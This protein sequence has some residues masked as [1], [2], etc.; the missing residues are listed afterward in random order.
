VIN[1]FDEI[2]EIDG[3]SL[4]DVIYSDMFMCRF[5][6]DACFDPN[7]RRQPY[8]NRD[9]FLYSIVMHLLFL[10]K[11]VEAE[12]HIKSIH[13]GYVRKDL[14]NLLNQSNPKEVIV[15]LALEVLAVR[16]RAHSLSRAPFG[17]L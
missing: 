8:M 17:I 16:T 2:Y 3:T 9:L 4:I 5:C 11:S 14:T 12:A 15:S 13:S 10:G 7:L 1:V 6:S